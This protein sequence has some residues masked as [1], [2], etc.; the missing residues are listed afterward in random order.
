[1]GL[2]DRLRGLDPRGWVGGLQR[3][4]TERSLDGAAQ[5]VVEAHGR[6]AIRNA[7]DRRAG[8]SIDG[9]AIGL[10]DIN[11]LGIGIGHQ[12]LILQRA[13]DGV[14]KRIGA[15]GNRLYGFFRIG[16]LIICEFTDRIFERS[17]HDRQRGGNNQQE[18]EW[19][20]T[21]ISKDF[22]KHW[23]TPAEAEGRRRKSP[24]SLVCSDLGVNQEP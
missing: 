13:D 18:C 10:F 24:P 20:R 3:Q 11:L 7:G 1:M 12:P 9:L 21:E 2:E 14:G 16:K 5:P 8:G 4:T 22:G 15:G 19:Q 23:S 17:R 6:R